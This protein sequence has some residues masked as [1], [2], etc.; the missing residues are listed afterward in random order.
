M[1]NKR[2]SLPRQSVPLTWPCPRVLGSTLSKHCLPG[3]RPGPGGRTEPKFSAWT[4]PR[5]RAT[6]K[7]LNG[8]DR[9][10]F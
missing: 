9:D 10:F 3:T 8:G 4:F 7:C 2:T 5:L 6:R 1:L